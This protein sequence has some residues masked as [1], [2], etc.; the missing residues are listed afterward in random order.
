MILNLFMAP[1]GHH[2]A[3][4]RLPDMEL[5]RIFD[6]SYYEELAQIAERGKFDSIFLADGSAL[7]D[8]AQFHPLARFDPLLVLTAMSRATSRIG[9][10]AT[11]STTFSHPFDV[12]RR[13]SSL[14]HISTGRA[15][16]NIVTTW[17][18]AAA[19]NFGLDVLPGHSA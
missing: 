8:S 1:P 2:F 19:A 15:G 16:W 14:D 13:F 10:I 5:E 12:A 11:V 9:L 17:D 4:W 6:I 7:S 18:D 3:A